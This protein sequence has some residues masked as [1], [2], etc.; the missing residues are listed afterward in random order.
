L[1]F[2]GEIPGRAGGVGEGFCNG[3][4]VRAARLSD[5]DAVEFELPANAKV[6]IDNPA[7]HASAHVLTAKDLRNSLGIIPSSG[8]WLNIRRALARNARLT[9]IQSAHRTK[10]DSVRFVKGE[11]GRC[12]RS[13]R[14]FTHKAFH[15]LKT[16]E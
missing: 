1:S 6:L 4:N 12:I 13:G 15:L 10:R 9:N 5:K 2:P 16:R 7:T 3:I 14:L 11:R 8:T